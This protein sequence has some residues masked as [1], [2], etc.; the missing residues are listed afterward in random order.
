MTSLGPAVDG[1]VDVLRTPTRAQALPEVQWSTLLATAR[2]TNLIGTL[3]AKLDAA[4]VRAPGRAE[5]HLAGARQLALRQRLSVRWEAHGLQA[6]LGGLGIP[7]VLLK[8]AAYVLS[9]HALGAGRMFGDI[10]ILV[11]RQAL[12]DVES[13]LM[14]DGWVSA[15]ADAYDQRYYR[16]WMHEL[17]PMSHIRRGT[18][19]DI[20]YTIL[21]LTARNAPDPA[22]IIARAQP[23]P[24]LP[25]LCVP[26]P[27]DLLIH[28]VT[29]LVH[30]G[31]LHNGLRDLHDIDSLLRTFGP[32]PGFWSSLVAQATG[33]DL[34][35]PLALGLRLA[36]SVF[37]SPL[38]SEAMDVLTAAA[39]PTWRRPWLP[40]LYGQALR[41]HTAGDTN[42][43]AATARF[44]IYV[45]AHALR[46]PAHLLARHLSIKAW[47]GLVVRDPAV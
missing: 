2:A 11:P 34:A 44:L 45:R 39:G 35:G 6:A 24:E 16:E 30:E 27:E 38:S 10:D 5:R 12:G 29:H 32:T 36:Q 41:P 40:A 43:R 22:R 17:P 26:T 14:L 8:G 13:A 18:V 25:A 19:I 15:K 37:N 3:A 7:V 42:P 28:S 46:M 20:H 1:L 4:G 21:P 33:N 47:K 23:V 9:P 31:E